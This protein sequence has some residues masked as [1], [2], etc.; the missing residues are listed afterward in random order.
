LRCAN[1]ST[2]STRLSLA[3][4]RARDDAREF[5]FESAPGG[6]SR[7]NSREISMSGCHSRSP[8]DGAKATCSP[9]RRRRGP[10]LSAVAPPAWP[11]HVRRAFV[12]YSLD[13]RFAHRRPLRDLR[14]RSTT[15]LTIRY[16]WRETER[17]ALRYV[18]HLVS[19]AVARQF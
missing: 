12:A 13:A 5:V 15:A 6:K 3:H 14:A 19:A 11:I 9:M 2:K 4:E 1:A 17:G 16:E 8:R 10:I 18:N 7:S